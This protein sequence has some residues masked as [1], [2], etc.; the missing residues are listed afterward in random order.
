M[1]AAAQE[2]PSGAKIFI[3]NRVAARFFGPRSAQAFPPQTSSVPSARASDS[4]WVVPAAIRRVVSQKDRSSSEQ[5]ATKSSLRQNAAAA[6]CSA[7]PMGVACAVRARHTPR[8]AEASRQQKRRKRCTCTS[9]RTRTGKELGFQ[10]SPPV[11]LL[12]AQPSGTPMTISS[13][14]ARCPAN[15]TAK[16]ELSCGSSSRTCVQLPRKLPSVPTR[17]SDARL[18]TKN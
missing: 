10:S 17:A 5:V 16:G 8:H 6:P 18:Q 11:A 12:S 7:Q 15:A 13:A 1:R 14:P 9:A 2:L 4:L 3:L